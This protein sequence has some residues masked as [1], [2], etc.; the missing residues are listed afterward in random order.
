[1]GKMKFGEKKYGLG[2][3]VWS[4]LCCDVVC[5]FLIMGIL[6]ASCKKDSSI[7]PTPI[8]ISNYFSFESASESQLL[9]AK[10][11]LFQYELTTTGQ[12][13]YMSLVPLTT[14]NPSNHVVFTFDYQS[15]KD[16]SNMQ[17]FFGSPVTEERS[18]KTGTLSA[19]NSWTTYSVDL[20]EY[21]K[22]FSWGDVGNFLRLDF[23][24]ESGVVIQIRNMQ[25]RIRNAE[26][27][28]LAKV[29]EDQIAYDLL[30]ESNIKRYLATSFNSSVTEVKVSAS[31]VSI[32]GNYSGDGIFSLCEVTPY[33]QLPQIS[34]FQNT[35][36][37]SS[38]SFSVDLDRFVNRDGFKYDRALSKWVIAR[39]GA[40]S[41]EIVSS[42]RYAD[43][44][45]ASQ[46]LQAQKPS[47]RKGLGGFAAARGFQ[48]DLNDLHITSAT[49]NIAF[50]EFMYLQPRSNAIAHTYGDKTYYFDRMRIDA[51]D[52][53]LQTTQSK[54]IVVAAIILVQKAAQCA[55]PEIGK[56]LQYPNYTSDG[57]YTMPNM[58]TAESLNCYAAALDFLASRYC[59]SDNAYGRIHYWIM[60]NEV[61]AGLSWTNMG[62]KP[63][64]VFMD[65]YIKSMRLCYNIARQYDAYSE[66][67]A[68]FTHS[69]DEPCGAK[70]YATKDMLRTLADFTTAEGDFLWGL[71]C[72]PYPQNL[73]E[74]KTWNDTKA[75]Y[76]M[77]SPLVTFKN[78]EVLDAWIKKPENKY[79]GIFKRT[80]WLS[81]NG[82]NSP[83]YSDTDLKEQAAGFAYT[84]KKMKSLDGIDAFQWH[85]WIDNRL[86]D[87]LRIGL[88]RFPDDSTDPGGKKPVWYV[89]QAA[90]TDQEDRVF[91]PYKSIIGISDWSQVQYSG[92]LQ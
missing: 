3:V 23:G 59:R 80:L 82:T 39:T 90:D 92:I 89:Y 14:T 38:A 7:T 76:S 77:N 37:L 30:L 40:T 69:W 64:A 48:T 5:S 88:R 36:A 24:N 2:F 25:L 45:P 66:V 15:T 13:P 11:G 18:L 84:W 43:Q 33:D 42:A 35:T 65:T 21:I 60:H 10:K 63:M 91:D 81:E 9:V 54:N 41:D 34:K 72:H 28:E 52:K 4:S 46:N 19:V 83:S 32:K 57:I 51:L 50:T 61:D 67:L 6:L 62:D 74:P 47:G 44:I 31:T 85:N 58:T 86:E 75:T 87:G 53:T 70:Y 79:K 29:R 78:L 68:S 27:A 20:G 56:L 55:D 17:F 16:I 8:I 26:E 71:A 22:M 1:M 49:V 73:F 12:D